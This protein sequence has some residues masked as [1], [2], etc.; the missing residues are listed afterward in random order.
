MI[1][2]ALEAF[3]SY[4]QIP[5]GQAN[6]QSSLT[7]GKLPIRNNDIVCC[8]RSLLLQSMRVGERF[9]PSPRQEAASKFMNAT[10]NLDS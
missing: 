5:M 6:R 7:G 9:A 2:K 4:N 10:C 8:C 1:H 3:C